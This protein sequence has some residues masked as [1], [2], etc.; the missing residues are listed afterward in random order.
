[1]IVLRW[2]LFIH[3]VFF[4]ISTLFLRF[5]LIFMKMICISD[6]RKKG[7]CLSFNVVASLAF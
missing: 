5:S 6:H 7:L 3:G 2:T 1:M 4:I